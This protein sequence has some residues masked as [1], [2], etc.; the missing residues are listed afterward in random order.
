MWWHIQFLRNQSS[1]LPGPTQVVFLFFGLKLFNPYPIIFLKKE[2][3]Y[4]VIN[5]KTWFTTALFV[6]YY[7]YSVSTV[8]AWARKNMM[9]QVVLLVPLVQHKISWCC[10]FSLTQYSLHTSTFLDA[11]DISTHTLSQTISRWLYFPVNPKDLFSSS[12]LRLPSFGRP[13]FWAS[14]IVKP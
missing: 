5:S 4:K 13:F 7:V 9:I 2:Q 11:L 12:S 1:L 8:M 10:M 14:V 6:S 3:T